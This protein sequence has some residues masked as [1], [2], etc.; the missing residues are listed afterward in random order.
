LG[1]LTTQNFILAIP[2]K[3]DTVK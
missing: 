1:V 2:A 3:W